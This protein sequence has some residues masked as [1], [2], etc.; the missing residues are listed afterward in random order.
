MIFSG[1][2]LLSND[3]AR[4]IPANI[5]ITIKPIPV[6]DKVTELVV[7]PQMTTVLT[8]SNFAESVF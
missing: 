8:D 3:R 5:E 2:T 1:E 7:S 6:T 4:A